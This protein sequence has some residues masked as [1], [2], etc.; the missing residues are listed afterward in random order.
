MF[1]LIKE[2]AGELSDVIIKQIENENMIDVKDFS[3]RYTVEVISSC[4]FGLKAN[5][6]QDGNSIFKEMA[7]N[8]F[9][10]SLSAKIVLVTQCVIPWLKKIFGISLVNKPV[11]KFFYKLTQDM[12]NHRKINNVR[13]NDF[14]QLLINMRYIENQNYNNRNQRKLSMMYFYNYL[15]S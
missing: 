11:T 7:L 14:L 1:D 9:G 12:I 6:I 15:L 8:I 10:R 4:A 2:C 13:R 3:T 5:T